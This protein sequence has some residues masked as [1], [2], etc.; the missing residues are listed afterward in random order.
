VGNLNLQNEDRAALRE[1]LNELV[2]SGEIKR[3]GKY[4]SVPADEN[5]FFTG[6]I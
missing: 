2:I 1:A 4:F 5:K 6:D 3:D